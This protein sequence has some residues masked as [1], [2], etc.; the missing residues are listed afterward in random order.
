MDNNPTDLGKNDRDRQASAA[1]II[2]T[3]ERSHPLWNF[4]RNIVVSS[5]VF[6][7]L[8]F[9]PS[10]DSTAQYSASDRSIVI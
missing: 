9:W 10:R 7:S 4:C 2:P 3:A 5:L 6:L 1:P 8:T